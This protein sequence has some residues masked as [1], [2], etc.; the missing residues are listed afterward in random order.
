MGLNVG[1]DGSM[2]G[3]AVGLNVNVGVG[4]GAITGEDA[5]PVPLSSLL[6]L[7][8]TVGRGEGADGMG[9]GTSVGYGVG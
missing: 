7:S 3:S 9:V 8:H 4:V 6:A 5:L 1:A 2:L